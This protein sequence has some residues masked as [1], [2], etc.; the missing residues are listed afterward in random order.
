MQTN[1]V[2]TSHCCLRHG[3]KYS[4]NDCPVEN[5]SKYQQFLC[6]YC[7][8]IP[9]FKTKNKYVEEVILPL[10]ILLSIIELRSTYIIRFMH[11]EK[12]VD[13]SIDK[14]YVRIMAVM[15]AESKISEL[16]NFFYPNVF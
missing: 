1:C 13:K 9:E 16:N 11:L 5:G 12:V 8:K 15:F 6:E 14:S 10:D 7:P 3:C 2:H 4:D